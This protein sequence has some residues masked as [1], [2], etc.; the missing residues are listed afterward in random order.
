MASCRFALEV[1]DGVGT[2]VGMPKV[3]P[4]SYA[5]AHAEHARVRA[6]ELVV[7]TRE[8]R[9]AAVRTTTIGAR[10][11][12]HPEIDARQ[13]FALLSRRFIPSKATGA[14][15]VAQY[16]LSGAGGGSWWVEVA[17]G[18]VAVHAGHAT[19]ADLT[20]RS[21]ADDY[22]RLDDGALSPTL[23]WIGGRVHLAGDRDL[24]KRDDA[25]FRPLDEV[26]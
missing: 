25:M 6:H 14:R 10:T 24:A 23:A 16:E 4:V 13:R 3:T 17:N 2:V 15:L 11:V 22:C 9:P 1:R 21:T 12:A 8:K 5:H 20:W 26:V 19:H 18:K 7:P